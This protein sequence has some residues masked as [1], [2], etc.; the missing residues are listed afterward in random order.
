MTEQKEK[1]TEEEI[2]E[3]FNF[4]ERYLETAEVVIGSNTV[5]VSVDGWVSSRDIPDEFNFRIVDT[6]D[7][8]TG[9]QGSGKIHFEADIEDLYND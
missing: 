6:R 8:C 5:C 2:R 7:D 3:S 9:N 1:I 4:D